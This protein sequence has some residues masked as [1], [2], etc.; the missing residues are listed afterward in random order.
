[1]NITKNLDFQMV[2][3]IAERESLKHFKLIETLDGYRSRRGALHASGNEGAF[4]NPIPMLEK[5]Y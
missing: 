2:G 3:L 4:E 5:H 1:M